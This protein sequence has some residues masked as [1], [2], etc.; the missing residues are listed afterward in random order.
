MYH[1]YVPLGQ[2]VA[3]LRYLKQ[4]RQAWY[5]RIGVPADLRD[6]I[7]K[8]DIVESLQTR[9][10]SVAQTR[11]WERVAHWTRTFEEMRG[12]AESV[13]WKVYRETLNQARAGAFG[14]AVRDGQGD[15]VSS[16]GVDFALE[17]IETE[18]LKANPDVDAPL[19]A[20]IQA[21]VDALNDYAKESAGKTLKIK[22]EYGMPFSECCKKYL[23][24]VKAELTNQTYGQYQAVFRLFSDFIKDKPM[25]LIG[26]KDAINFLDVISTFDPNWGRSPKTKSRSFQELRQLY[27]GS[28]EGLAVRTLNRYVTSLSCAWKWAKRRQEANGDNPFD[29]LFRAVNGKNSETYVPYETDELNKLFDPLP[30]NAALWEIPLVALYTGMRLNEICSLAWENVRQQDGVWYFD[31]VAAKSEAGVRPVPIHSKLAWLLERRAKNPKEPIWPQLKPGGPDKK[32][33]WYLSGDFSEYRR[34]RG[35][36]GTGKAFHSFR[37]NAT[38]CL[39]RARVPQNEAA[40]I[41]GHEKAGITYRVYNPDGMTMRQRQDTVEKIVYEGFEIPGLGG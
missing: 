40:E 29:G 22:P 23:A 16:S 12:N 5:F 26:P 4:R 39:E 21:K 25:R 15:E 14:D 32:L 18:W 6:K 28:E 35:V 38:R 17:A 37:K 19:P 11:R 30:K 34:K 9:D 7:G 3:D 31:I 10:L 2:F 24:D 36:V 1:H 13:P 8:V 27:S 41:I 20:A 33:S